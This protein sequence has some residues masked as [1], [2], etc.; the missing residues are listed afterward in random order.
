MYLFTP[1]NSY[2]AFRDLFLDYGRGDQFSYHA[3]SALFDYLEEL[4]KSTGEPLRVDVV[5]LCCGWT[6]YDG[7]KDLAEAY[8]L[9]LDDLGLDADA[10]ALEFRDAV[11]EEMRSRGELIEFG[12]NGFLFSEGW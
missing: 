1:M 12:D 11:V 3:Y 4:A 8:C 6:E 5:A 2:A 9:T 10:D 7:A